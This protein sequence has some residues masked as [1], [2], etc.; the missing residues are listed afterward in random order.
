MCNDNF[1]MRLHARLDTTS[2]PV[3]KDDIALGIAAAYPLTVG[4]ETNLA[5]VSGHGVTCKTLLPVLAEIICAVYE[6][7]VI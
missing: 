7:L 4:R 5:C 6:D 3:P 1:G 2:F